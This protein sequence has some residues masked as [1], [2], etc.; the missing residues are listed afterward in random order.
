M[1]KSWLSLTL[2]LMLLPA[3]VRGQLDNS[4]FYDQYGI[5]D[6]DSASI[7]FG[8][9]VF[10]YLRNNEFREDPVPGYTLFGY[11]FRPY[12]SYFP[13]GRIRLDAG[14]FFQKDF[15]EENFTDIRPLVTI[16]YAVNNFSLI[17]GTL[18]GAMSHRLI[19]P[20]YNFENVIGR[21]IEDGLQLKYVSNKVFFDTWIEW[22]NMIDFGEDALEEFNYGISLDVRL[23]ESPAFI[24]DL[25]VQL[26]ANHRGGEIDISTEPANTI[27]NGAVGFGL[28]FPLEKNGLL[29]S[30]R[31]D[32]Y[33]G[34]YS[35]SDDPGDL[36]F[37]DGDGWFMNL[38]G[39]SDWFDVMFSYWHGNQFYAP[40]GGPL[41]QSVFFIDENTPE[42]QDQRDLLFLRLL[43]Q[44]D[45]SGAVNLAFRFEP[46]YDIGNGQFDHSEG[47]YLRYRTDFLLNRKRKP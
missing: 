16:R 28:E 20:L 25:P 37:L 1:N 7:K 19:E 38:T 21:R 11:Q 35:S 33:Y 15:G 32:G 13:T 26:L 6:E 42:T 3:L 10:G 18:E 4:A 39:K 36:P 29:K 31:F 44:H 5:T 40:F 46:V 27:L 17:F 41:Y 47:L 45:L 23:F 22:I 34:I 12:F 14:G 30:V 2:F 8:F 43:F 9:E 24:L